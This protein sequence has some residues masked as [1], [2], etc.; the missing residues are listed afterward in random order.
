LCNYGVAQQYTRPTAFL[1][2]REYQ[3]QGHAQLMGEQWKAK[4]TGYQGKL[5]CKEGTDHEAV[6]NVAIDGEKGEM[7]RNV[8]CR[9]AARN[10]K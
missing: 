9:C 7:T 5:S 3:V 6:Q 8:F 4:T 2:R 1:G 10:G